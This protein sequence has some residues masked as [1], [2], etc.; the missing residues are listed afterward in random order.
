MSKSTKTT[1]E[2]KPPEW[3]AEGLKRAGADALALYDNRVGF[4][5]YRGPT[6]ADLSDP[7]L[8]GM[9]S[10]LAATG[11]QGAPISNQSINSTL[12]D[13]E[14]IMAQVLQ[15]KQPSRLPV[16]PPQP[17]QPGPAPVDPEE[18]MRRQLR[19]R[20]ENQGMR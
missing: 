15:N 13:I 9:N 4:D 16:Q 5:T 19:A 11:Y 17:M 18:E 14:A 7:T 12:P 10:L 6:Q 2:N 1:Q 20:F 8:S 3:A